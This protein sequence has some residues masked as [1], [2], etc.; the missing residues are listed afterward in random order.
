[1]YVNK[2]ASHSRGSKIH[3][4]PDVLTTPPQ[5]FFDMKAFVKPREIA[6]YFITF[7]AF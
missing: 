4:K 3:E 7:H 1:M 6:L 2:N 5:T